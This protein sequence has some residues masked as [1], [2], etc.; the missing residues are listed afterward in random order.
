MNNLQT[1]VNKYLDFCQFQ[2]CLDK[3]TI[4]AYKIDLKQFYGYIYFNKLTNITPSILENFIVE[5]HQR[6]KPKTTKRKI[7]TLKAFFHYLEYKDIIELNPFNKINIKF[8]EPVILPK[9]IPLYLIEARLSK[10]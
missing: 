2:K 5:L 8:R 4:K 7:A 6:Y 3:K 1:T 10:K 9:T